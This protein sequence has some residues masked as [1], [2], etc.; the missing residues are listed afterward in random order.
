MNLPIPIPA[1]GLSLDEEDDELLQPGLAALAR[2][3]EPH[4]EDEVVDGAERVADDVG[5]EVGH[6]QH[7]QDD[8]EDVVQGEGA[9]A[10]GGKAKH[11]SDQL[12]H[13]P[14][15]VAPGDNPAAARMHPILHINTR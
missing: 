14:I 10:H 1:P 4:A 12:L 7:V 13:N 8:E 2:E 5:D 11:L 3:H 15:I 6:P 9:Q